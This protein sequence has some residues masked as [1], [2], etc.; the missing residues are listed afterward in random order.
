MSYL[1]RIIFNLN[2]KIRKDKMLRIFSRHDNDNL[3]LI[4]WLSVILILMA[5]GIVNYPSAGAKHLYS[6]QAVHIAGALSLWYDHDLVYTLADLSRF[7]GELPSE[8]GPRGAFLKVGDDNQLYYAKPFLYALFTSPFVGLFGLVGF[9]IFNMICVG[10]IGLISIKILTRHI[11]GLN[12]LMLVSGLMLFSP[13][14][15]WTPVSHP[16]IFIATLLILGGYLLLS[17]R[18]DRVILYKLSGAF[19]M[20]MAVY[21][22]PT[23]IIFAMA[24]MVSQFSLVGFRLWLMLG[25]VMLV[26]WFLPTSVHLF[27]DGNLLPYQGLRFKVTSLSIIGTYPLEKDWPGVPDHGLTDKIFNAMTLFNAILSNVELLPEKTLDLFVGRQTGL[28]AYFPVAVLLVLLLLGGLTWR[29]IML[30]G[31]FFTYLVI[32]WLA[33]PTN[34]YGGSGSY[35]PRYTMQALPMIVI[36][37]VFFSKSAFFQSI[38]SRKGLVSGVCMSGLMVSVA[39]QSNV[40][41]LTE[42]NVKSPSNY[43]L[44]PVGEV[45][46]LETSLLPSVYLLMPLR[47][48]GGSDGGRDAIFRTGAKN[49]NCYNYLVKNDMQLDKLVLFQGGSIKPVSRMYLYAT[50]DMQVEF[51]DNDTVLASVLAKSNKLVNVDLGDVYTKVYND[52]IKGDV[53]WKELK[54]RSH[55][56]G[57]ETAIPALLDIGFVKKEILGTKYKLG[58]VLGSDQFS[59]NG[60][61][62]TFCW[63][64]D[65]LNYWSSGH[66]AGFN[67]QLSEPVSNDLEMNVWFKPFYPRDKEPLK[68]KLFVNSVMI[69]QYEFSREDGVQVKLTATLP[70]EMISDEG[71]IKLMFHVLNPSQPGSND[72]RFLGMALQKVSLSPKIDNN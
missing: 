71:N 41:P 33:F 60:I 36:A 19:I 53:K 11:G 14:L 66:Y 27:Q 4:L 28:L 64:P 10:L 59:S 26:G 16:D 32:Y 17:D 37:F 30:V 1:Q 5:V 62:P 44:S 35:G 43:M 8:T 7:R 50:R 72:Y 24:L 61:S 9:L 45:F 34:G 39:V 54:I 29:S 63:Q 23:F 56:I 70:K 31:A 25:V 57:D 2:K 38:I 47:F 20:G 21:E 67:V 52:R 3:A 42:D 46:S 40:F 65:P 6:D 58:E 69:D 68:V 49:K 48:S 51:I 22:K 55:L 18:E 13:Y 12:A 15:A